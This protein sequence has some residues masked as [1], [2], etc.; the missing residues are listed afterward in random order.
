MG[1]FEAGAKKFSQAC[2]SCHTI[3]KDAP[4]GNGPNLNGV[5]LR[6]AGQASDYSYSDAMLKKGV[7]WDHDNLMEFLKNPKI[8][9]PKT[10]MGF[11]GL[12]SKK[13]RENLVAYLKKTSE[14]G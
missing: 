3:V 6:Q 12:K 10:K 11:A 8:F 1:D 5:Y 13:D 7:I 4:H 14:T 9:V 2:K